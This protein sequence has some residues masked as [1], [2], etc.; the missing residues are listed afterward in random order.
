MIHVAKGEKFYSESRAFFEFD[1]IYGSRNFR[2]PL[3][4]VPKQSVCAA[5]KTTQAKLRSA[6]QQ[7]AA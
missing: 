4:R 7:K 6:A 2:N 5:Q 3:S 1:F